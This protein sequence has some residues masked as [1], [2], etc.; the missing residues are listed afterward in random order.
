MSDWVQI[1]IGVCLLILAFS[2]S[3]II[4]AWQLK[5]AA[6]FIVKDLQ[7]KKAL[8][9]DSAVELPYSKTQIFRLGIRDYR[10]KV[11][12]YMV[13]QGGVGITEDNRYYLIMRSPFPTS[14]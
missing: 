6:R 7:T 9:P 8:D 11:L 1:A 14:Q 13:A 4:V 2:L 12:E 5:R 3:R 10:P